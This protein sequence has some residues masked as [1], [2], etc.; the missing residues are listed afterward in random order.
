MPDYATR[1]DTIAAWLQREEDE[2]L[3]TPDVGVGT[4]GEYVWLDEAL[5]QAAIDWAA[6]SDR[7]AISSVVGRVVAVHADG[8]ISVRLGS[9]PWIEA[10]DAPL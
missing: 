2:L 10:I 9:G 6:G 5:S 3:Y 7:T 4:S 1:L 8:C